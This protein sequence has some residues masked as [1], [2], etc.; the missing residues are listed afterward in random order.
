VPS[1]SSVASISTNAVRRCAID[2]VVTD[3]G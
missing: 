1:T 3:Q 2:V